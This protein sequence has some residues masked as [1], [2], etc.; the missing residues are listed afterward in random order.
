MEGAAH[1]LV[2]QAS[3]DRR[4]RFSD[5]DN[6][7]PG[8]VQIIRRQLVP[9]RLANSTQILEGQPEL[10][11]YG[12]DGTGNLILGAGSFAE[13]RTTF[14]QICDGFQQTSRRNLQIG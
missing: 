9:A 3:L 1:K 2:K 8:V 4:K 10:D 12:G 6:S 13:P 7:N 5:R 14:M 11:R